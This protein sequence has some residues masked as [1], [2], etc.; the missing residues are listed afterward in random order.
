MVRQLI[1]EEQKEC[2][3]VALRIN[4]LDFTIPFRF[5]SIKSP[6][7]FIWRRR[8]LHKKLKKTLIM[9]NQLSLFV[10]IFLLVAQLQA[11]TQI[12]SYVPSNGLVGYWPFNGNANDE[13]G[14]GNHGVVNGVVSG[15]TMSSLEFQQLYSDCAATAAIGSAPQTLCSLHN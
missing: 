5:A 12:P 3:F 1:L 15:A 10:S 6:M 7:D 4:T 11:Q 13:S 14:N 2:L 8:P 9:K